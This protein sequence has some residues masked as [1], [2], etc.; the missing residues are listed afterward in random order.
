[1]GLIDGPEAEHRL[2]TSPGPATADLSR[3]S[4]HRLILK[5]WQ[6]GLGTPHSLLLGLQTKTQAASRRLEE[7]RK[8][9]REDASQCKRVWSVL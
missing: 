6:R 4:A 3:E 8:W 9:R 2:E 7:G 1:M 5:A